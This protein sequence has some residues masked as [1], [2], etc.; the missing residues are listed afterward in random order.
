[1]LIN[2]LKKYTFH[3]FYD[4]FM[5]LLFLDNAYLKEFRKYENFEL[6][7][8]QNEKYNFIL[9]SKNMTSNTTLKKVLDGIISK[10]E[11]TAD[12]AR[13]ANAM[14]DLVQRLTD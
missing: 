2:P 3:P 5:V 10:N 4:G 6:I 13:E 7:L 1:V 12:I 9:V 11:T 8:I 14:N